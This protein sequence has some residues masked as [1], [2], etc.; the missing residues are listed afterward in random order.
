MKQSPSR[1]DRLAKIGLLS[2]LALVLSYLETMVPLPVALP[3]VK[4]GLANVAVVVALFTMDWK[5][6]AAVAAAKVVASGLLFGSPIMLAYSLGGMAL[7]FAGMLA[8]RAVPGVGAVAVSMVSAVLHNAGQLAVAAFMLQTPAVVINLAPL[9]VAALITGLLTG[10]VAAQAIASVSPRGARSSVSPFVERLGC[11]K[12]SERLSHCGESAKP[13]EKTEARR[14]RKQGQ[15]RSEGGASVGQGFFS[16]GVFR[17]GYSFMHRLDPRAKII[18]SLL[19]IVAAFVASG[20]FGMV[21]IA[22]VA[23]AAHMLAGFGV[24]EAFRALKPFGWLMGFIVVFDCLFVNSGEVLFAWGFVCVSLGGIAFAAQSVVRFACMLLATSTLMATT[25][26]TQLTDAISALLAPLR[27]LGIR[28]DDVALVLGLT[29]RFIPT[30]SNELSRIKKAQASRCADF[31]SG[32]WVC[33]VVRLATLATPLLASALR[34]STIL[35]LSIASRAYGAKSARTC[36]RA[37]RMGQKDWA[38]LASSAI[39]LLVCCAL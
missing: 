35:A 14:A 18:F 30:F 7:A 39:L 15:A 33:R 31:T 11:A 2:S 32:S 26:P 1:I 28:V 4:L 19:Y 9:S 12:R 34:K 3:G 36:A 17:P 22:L 8:L 20:A 21:A 38:L 5:S 29:L 24:R 10:T 16:F 37:Y 27:R 6:A 23:L 25:S 13:R